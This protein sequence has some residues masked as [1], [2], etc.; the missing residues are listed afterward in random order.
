VGPLSDDKVVDL[1]AKNCIPVAQNLYEIRKAKGAAGDF[2]RDVKKQ[3]PEQYQGLYLVT[4]DGKVLASH[5]NFKTDKTWAE[6]CLADL[7]SGLEAFG[8][9]KPR[10]VKVVD[11]LPER[12]VG[13]RKD[14]G[15]CL[16]IYLRLPIK[17]IPLREL[18]NPTIDSLVLT[19]DEFKELT[20]AKPE[21]GFEWKLT[22]ALGRKFSRVLGPGDEDTM[23]RPNEVTA[24]VLTGKVKSV[25]NGTAILT[26][27]GEIAG[28]HEQQSSKGKCHGQV[29]LTGVGTYD[30]KA[31]RLQSVVWVLDGNYTGPPPNDKPV[32]PYS[33][34]VEWRRERPEK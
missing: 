29:K 20:P 1:I 14:G 9:V 32:Q 12:G 22:E 8:E 13:L 27:E 16:A 7:R 31:A 21:A 33:G 3:K 2:F 10:D 11:P 17:G 4:G 6:D 18:P 28:A 24:V 15:A 5:Q 19:A 34:V 26:F 25:D 30:V 23:P